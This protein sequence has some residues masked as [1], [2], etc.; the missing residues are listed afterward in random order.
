MDSTEEQG[1]PHKD[2]SETRTHLDQQMN[3]KALI[4]KEKVGVSKC[5]WSYTKGLNSL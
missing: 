5:L 1:D 4:L 2:T 3:T